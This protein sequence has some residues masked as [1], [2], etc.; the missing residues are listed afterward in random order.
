[1]RPSNTTITGFGPAQAADVPQVG[2]QVTAT[3]VQFAPDESRFRQLDILQNQLSAFNNGQMASA[4]LDDKLQ[5]QRDAAQA[6]MDFLRNPDAEGTSGSGYYYQAMMGLHAEKASL[7]VETQIRA[8]QD[9][10]MNSPDELLGTNVA[11]H[12]DKFSKS[13]YAG[14]DDPIVASKVL[15]TAQAST[16]SAMSS[17]SSAKTKLVKEDTLKSAWGVTWQTTQNASSPEDLTQRL[18]NLLTEHSGLIGKEAALG[19]VTKAVGNA[20]AEAPTGAA[21]A[22]YLAALDGKLPDGSTLAEKLGKQS[23]ELAS[24]VT[25]MRTTVGN[26]KAADAAREIQAQKDAIAAHNAKVK[27]QQDINAATFD[28]LV[29]EGTPESLARARA[30]RDNGGLST[31]DSI[32]KQTAYDKALVKSTDLRQALNAKN[33]GDV[34][35]G[36]KATVLLEHEVKLMQ[37]RVSKDPSSAAMAYSAAA[38]TLTQ[39]APTQLEELNKTV[40]SGTALLLANHKP[41]QPMNPQLSFILKAVGGLH[42]SEVAARGIPTAD[43]EAI[44]LLKGNLQASGSDFNTAVQLTQTSLMSGGKPVSA[45]DA[46][47][48][49][50]LAAKGMMDQMLSSDRA[51]ELQEFLASRGKSVVG[52]LDGSRYA[53]TADMAAVAKQKMAGEIIHVGGYSWG[54]GLKNTSNAGGVFVGN[55]LDKVHARPLIE[56]GANGIL[57]GLRQ[58]GWEA[59]IIP[60]DAKGSHVIVARKAGNLSFDPTGTNGFF[61]RV[62]PVELRL[63][64]SLSEMEAAGKSIGEHRLKSAQDSHLNPKAYTHEVAVQAFELAKAHAGVTADKFITPTTAPGRI[65]GDGSSKPTPGTSAPRTPVQP[66]L[67]KLEQISKSTTQAA[68]NKERTSVKHL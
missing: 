1:M 34:L 31:V 52:T 7:D 20:I 5:Q 57:S 55:G 9:R 40:F 41:G 68:V 39:S 65:L 21:A 27:E 53:S 46:A 42:D 49:G 19:L 35:T 38:A 58:D 43:Y 14:L 56:D 33:T 45:S 4:K 63:P 36:T 51:P 8:E 48:A 16:S 11:E 3:P 6:Q 13:L 59:T 26:L 28:S 44:R 22:G 37:D 32:R 10:L 50:Q 30:I 17:L 61:P 24:A 23:P 62:N 60:T 12:M 2:R 29:D 18:G 67:K 15:K 66:A 54:D 25:K 47:E 64:I